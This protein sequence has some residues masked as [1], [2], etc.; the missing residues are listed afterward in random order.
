MTKR[1][2]EYLNQ[3]KYGDWIL[4]SE[5]LQEEPKNGL[6]NIDELQEYIVMIAGATVPTTLKYAGNGEW[7]ADGLFYHVIT[8]QPL[9]ESYKE[10]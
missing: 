5:R 10:G 1:A 8:W 7:Y 6:N 4:C 9:P 3:P 2:R